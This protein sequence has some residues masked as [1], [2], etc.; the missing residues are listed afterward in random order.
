MQRLYEYRPLPRLGVLGSLVVA[1]FLGFGVLTGGTAGEGSGNLE[2]QAGAAVVVAVGTFLFMFFV[3]QNLYWA[4][5]EEGISW[6]STSGRRRRVSWE[7]IARGEIV[8]VGRGAVFRS[9][10]LRLWR[11]DGRSLLVR[12]SRRHGGSLDPEALRL[13]E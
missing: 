13:L 12:P 6:R 8:W 1:L 10:A 9:R 4:I 7:D 3:G 2:L 5:E 11:R